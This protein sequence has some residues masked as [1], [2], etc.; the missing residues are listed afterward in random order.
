MKKP[1]G[2]L[3]TCPNGH[4]YY[5]SSDCPVCPVR[6]TF[7]MIVLLIIISLPSFAQKARNYTSV[8]DDLT[9]KIS[10]TVPAGKALHIA[11]VPF[12]ATAASIEKGTA[13]GEYITESIIGSLT[14]QPD[15]IKVF[16]RTRLD[17]VLKEQEFILTD[18]MKPS[19]ALKIGQL[20]PIDALLSGT[21]TK[22]KSYIDVNARLID[23]A[24]GEISVSF[25]GRIKMTK[26]L[27]TLFNQGGTPTEK[28][29]GKTVTMSFG[30]GS[31]NDKKTGKTK[32]AAEIC[33]EQETHITT[34]LHDLTS[35][36]KIKTAVTEAK[37]LPFDKYCGVHYTV[38]QSFQRYKIHNDEYKRFLLAGVDTV[39]YPSDDE[40]SLTAAEYL[41][42]D[43]T[44]DDT[45]WATF[46]RAMQKIGTYH[47]RFFNERLIA[48]PS[49]PDQSVMESRIASYFNLASAGK[50]GLP[51]P[52]SYETAFT[53]MLDGLR[54]NQA[55]R[56]HVYATYAG[57]LTTDD[58]LKSALFS[59]LHQMYTDA[60]ADH[61]PEVMKWIIDLINNNDYP[62][63]PEQLYDFAREL[64]RVQPTDPNLQMLIDGCRDRFSKYALQ[65]EYQSQKEDR[66]DFCVTHNIAIPGVIPT[67]E[68]ADAILKGNNVAEQLRITKML[69]MMGDRPKKI[70]SSL[71]GLL[72]KR[73]L[74]DRDALLRAQTNAIAILGNIRTTN[75][76]AVDYMIDVLPHYGNDTEAAKISLVQIGKP[77][78][79][80]LVAELS[81]T[82]DQN[83]GLQYQLITIL[84]KIGKDATEA[85]S[86]ITRVLNT[87]RNSD[88]KY[89]AEA[90][91]QEIKN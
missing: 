11:V 70:E 83:G 36:D 27:A 46:F 51:R 49:A 50:I 34:M 58:R 45:E 25:N 31:D 87:T 84:G 41:A 64:A 16:E 68:E 12:T 18:L 39:G 47:L 26:N 67:M 44:V 24:T 10:A 66:I 74:D 56:R 2:T 35:E 62:K 5:K 65:S 17:A 89:A 73:S 72:T 3:R 22:L 43:G 38:M 53:H 13:F 91:L 86:A 79:K 52:I 23:V 20:V 76:K 48:A 32:S 40:R 28:D 81:K 69:A 29:N 63:A 85:Q 60:D 61:K 59:S 30:G 7:K 55:L 82:N 15:K 37:K 19:A 42:S 88:V 4:Q 54:K 90:A 75:P 8:T 80:Q 57:K 71:I 1:K 9:S 14:G 6:A 78:V 77:A 21:Y 33:K